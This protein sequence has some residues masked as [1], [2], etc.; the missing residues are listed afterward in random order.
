MKHAGIFKMPFV[1]RNISKPPGARDI[2]RLAS[3]IISRGKGQQFQYA[4]GEIGNRTIAASGGDQWGANLRFEH[5]SANNLNQYTSR[6]VPGYVQELGSANSNA[7]VTVNNARAYRHGEFFRAEVPEDNSASALWLSLTNLAVLANGTNSDIA[8]TNIGNTFLPQTPEGFSYDLDGNITNDGRWSYTWDPE[9]RLIAMT[10]LSS[11]PAG[12]KLKLDMAYDFQGRRIQKLV[13]TNNGSAYFPQSTNRFS[14]DGWNLVGEFSGP[15]VPLRLYVWGLD[16]SGSMQDAGG[17]GGLLAVSEASAAQTTNWNLVTFDGGGNV[18]VIIRSSNG[19]EVSLYEYGPFGEILRATGPAAGLTTPRFSS[20]YQDSATDLLYYGYRYYDSFGGRWSS[21]DPME[22][23]SS[24]NVYA[25][26][27]NNPGLHIDPLGL[28]QL[29]WQRN[30]CEGCNGANWERSNTCKDKPAGKWETGSSGA[31]SSNCSGNSGGMCDTETH[32]FIHAGR[33]PF[34]CCSKWKVTCEFTYDGTAV[35][36]DAAFIHLTGDFLGAGFSY[37]DG[38]S[39]KGGKAS[40]K[41][42]F[43]LTGTIPVTYWGWT[44]IATM[45]PRVRADGS[46]FHTIDETGS[47]SC[48]AVCAKSGSTTTPN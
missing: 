48:S 11:S 14:Y 23:T 40:L 37:F 33:G 7:T 22:E 27:Q 34:N 26:L 5:Y 9:N 24:R 46:V 10:S 13:S 42:N 47:V 1:E 19:T 17:I 45:S 28:V 25:A 32:V 43:T 44:H 41:K 36:D 38:A 15:T 29:Q 3:R 6:T 12:S 18:S 8:A 35:G 30:Q 39:N 20:K 16:L 2:S 31:F 21:R 4:F